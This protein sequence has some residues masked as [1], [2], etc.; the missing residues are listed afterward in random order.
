MYG[1]FR[2]IKRHLPTG[3]F[4]RSLI[5][6][7][8]PMVLLQAILTYLFFERH[9]D[10]VTSRLSHL[11]AGD[12]ALVVD[13]FENGMDTS[14]GR[15]FSETQLQQ[16]ADRH[17]GL[18]IAFLP[19]AD[20]P[21]KQDGRFLS[22]LDRTIAEEMDR[23]LARPYWFDTE[24]HEKYV[25][26]R[27]KVKGGVLHVL[28]LRSRMLA[29]N[30][31]IFLVWMV[32]T[33][34][35][36]MTIAVLFLR[37]QVRPIERLAAAAQAFGRGRP[38]EEFKP[39]GAAEVRAAAEAFNDMR[40]RIARQI[41]QRT[42]MLAGVS[43]DLK[44]P[45]TR[46]QLQ[47]AM[48]E[49]SEAVRALREDTRHM[50]GMLDEYLAFARGEAGEASELINLAELLSHISDRT[51]RDECRLT[52]V[53]SGDIWIKARPNA[54][55]RALAN[56]L[57]NACGIARSVR[58]ST[59]SV[60]D[61]IDILVDDDG[62]GIPAPERETVFRPFYRRDQARNQDRPGTG[63]GLA[64]ARD[65][66]RSHGGDIILQDSPLGGLRA[67]LHLPH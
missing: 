61:G 56:L 30:W 64:V 42:A 35:L 60:A 36:L 11:T 45:L 44:T 67:R 37:N 2:H 25:D 8:A 29:T 53:S 3:L 47:L 32:G 31:H 6:V 63:L 46:F 50:A 65:I 21:K 55:R 1:L 39:H 15:N 17:L 59:E 40:R 28:A 22:V 14:T 20:L 7:V 5:I 52:V 18:R 24:A 62:P 16:L 43:H 41:E 12:I 34:L 66:A 49:D 9:W 13:L 54:L 51:H 33:S 23:S 58:L 19:R 26:I 57:D 10:L 27:V 48:M 38:V 4:P